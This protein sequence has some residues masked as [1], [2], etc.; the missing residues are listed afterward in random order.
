MPPSHLPA[1]LFLVA[2]L[3]SLGPRSSIGTFPKNQV[4]D[5]DWFLNVAINQQITMGCGVLAGNPE[6]LHT[7]EKGRNHQ[8]SQRKFYLIPFSSLLERIPAKHK[9]TSKSHHFLLQNWHQH[10]CL[11]FKY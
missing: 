3:R 5:G 6:L 2:T 8:K 10:P 1:E 7:K 9:E 11:L 4:L